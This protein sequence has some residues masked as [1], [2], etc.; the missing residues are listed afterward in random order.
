[1][2]KQELLP[3]LDLPTL[4]FAPIKNA[5]RALLNDS[6]SSKAR[7]IFSSFFMDKASFKK[8]Y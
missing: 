4:V 6:L 7:S 2:S 1:M 8:V 5:K 3:S